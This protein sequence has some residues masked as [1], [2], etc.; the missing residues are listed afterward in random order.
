MKLLVIVLGL[1]AAAVG[2]TGNASA[3]TIT[4]VGMFS[5]ANQSP[6]SVLAAANA[7]GVDSNSD[8]LFA[9]RLGS[10][11]SVTNSFG[12]FTVNVLNTP[13][14]QLE[15]L[16]FSLIPGF[17]VAGI[18]INGGSGQHDNFW[19]INDMTTGRFFGP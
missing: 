17:I 15:F 18:G 7:A 19:S 5:T 16:T 8:L 12:T 13:I 4:F 3:N 9:A 10:P 6:A 11:G 2:L 1:L 14:G